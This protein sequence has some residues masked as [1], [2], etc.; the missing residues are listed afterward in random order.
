M[1]DFLRSLKKI[2][3]LAEIVSQSSLGT[4][5]EYLST[6]SYSLNAILSGDMYKGPP[7][8]RVLSLVG[9]PSTGKSY[10]MAN[11]IREAQHNNYYTAAF[12]TENASDKFFFQRLGVNT[13]LLIDMPIETIEELN[14]QCVQVI[15]SFAESRL[16]NPELKLFLALDSFGNL[17]TKRKS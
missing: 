13:D 2:N 9:K 14:I 6:G 5:K 15:E 4:I 10:V 3:P 11:L 8:G 1:S 12:Q 17:M 16:K 7:S